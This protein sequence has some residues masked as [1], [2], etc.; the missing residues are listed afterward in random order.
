ML[1][2]LA[3]VVVLVSTVVLS[4]EPWDGAKAEDIGSLSFGREV[5]GVLKCFAMHL[6]R[7]RWPGQGLCSSTRGILSASGR[8]ASRLE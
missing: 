3:V 1:I 7:A 2:S 6:V 4:A 5:A 8:L